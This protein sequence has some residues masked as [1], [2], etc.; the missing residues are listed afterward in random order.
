MSV[1][2]PIALLLLLPLLF[3]YKRSKKISL[4]FLSIAFMIVALSDIRVFTT[5][6]DEKID[7]REFIIALDLSRSMSVDDIKPNRVTKA[8]ELIRKM[9]DKNPK[10]SF[11]LFAF[12]TN[13][14]ILSPPT[15]DHNLIKNALRSIDIKNIL[16]KGTDIIS[17]LK[18]VSKLKTKEKNLIIFSDGGDDIELEK[19]LELAK[20]QHIT[21]SAVG[22][23]TKDG[24]MLKDEYNEVIRDEKNHIVIS[25]LN[26]IL[27][28]LAKKSGGFYEDFG[29]FDGILNDTLSKKH[30]EK[31]IVG[32]LRL[33]WIPL[34]ISTILFILHFIKIPKKLIL[35]LPVLSSHTEASMIFDWYHIKEAKKAYNS[36]DYKKAASEFSKIETKTM[37]SML[38][39][40]NSYYQMGKYKE[41][42]S[43]YN[44]LKSSDPKY[45]K[46]IL[47]KK[48]NTLSHLK[49]YTEAKRA[50]IKAL[51]FGKDEDILYNLR[52]I[53]F[54]EETKR[55][56][57]A[58]KSKEQN[59]KNSATAKNDTKKSSSKKNSSNQE[60][61]KSSSS[62]KNSD[63][64]SIS[65]KGSISK[66]PSHPLSYKAYDK[67]N[68]GYIYEKKPW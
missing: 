41:A 5:K 34:L 61:S 37:Q 67:I 20:K 60:G 55:K 43:I 49:R 66:S 48:A 46:I 10:D 62:G 47:F 19:T 65:R 58:V 2:Y 52:L 57:P 36:K 3:V 22:V 45:K 54:K 40:A 38:N 50:Y 6:K 42:L 9:L 35:L 53:L 28:V 30:I 18:R 8:K 13:A 1:T 32:E 39:L 26:P 24:A 21:I 14:L 51:S 59:N 29:S 68:K 31:Q 7:A 16:S 44:S 11:T 23:A 33:F 27:K 56:R 17:L 25:H 15:T 4:L 64:K 63:T 12:T